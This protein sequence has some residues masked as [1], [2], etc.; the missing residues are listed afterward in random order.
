MV[1]FDEGL[2]VLDKKKVP[3]EVYDFLV[4]EAHEFHEGNEEVMK[5][6]KGTALKT[7]AT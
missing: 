4:E 5:K 7:D 2:M 6:V 1:R 3:D